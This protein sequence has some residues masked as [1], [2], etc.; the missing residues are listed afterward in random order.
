MLTFASIDNLEPP[1]HQTCSLWTVG[2]GQSTQKEPTQAQGETNVC[3]IN[4]LKHLPY[5]MS[6]RIV[7][8]CN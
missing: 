7:F 4:K 3:F 2:G 6:S 8:K 5:V 1:V